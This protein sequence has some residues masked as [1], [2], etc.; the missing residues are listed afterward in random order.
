MKIDDIGS[1][2]H[3]ITLSRIKANS[4]DDFDTY[5]VFTMQDLSRETGQY[6]IKEELQKVNICKNKFD[7]SFLSRKNMVV[8]GLTSYKAM[9]IGETHK[10][11]LITSNFAIME[12]DESKIDPFYFTW[13]FNE[14]PEIQ[15]QLAIAMQGTFIR[16]LSVQMLRELE[17]PMPQLYIQKKIGKVYKL[18]KTKEKL[19]F[20][21]SILENELYNQLMINK[22]KELQIAIKN[23]NK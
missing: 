17:L 9:V 16:A 7:L 14:H 13:Y 22:L 2:T 10:E 6:S 21:R 15:K 1:V 19:L 18:R 4:Y 8:I 23:H 20:E 5:K 3:G 11:K 12:F